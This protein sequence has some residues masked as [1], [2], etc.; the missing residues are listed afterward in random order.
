MAVRNHGDNDL[1]VL[2]DQWK[3]LTIAEGDC[4]A[5]EDWLRLDELQSQK[6]ASQQAIETAHASLLRNIS[7]NQRSAVEGRLKNIAKEVL[8]LESQN[9]ERLT[10]KL[11]QTSTELRQLDK[12]TRSMGRVHRAYGTADRS[13]WQ[14]YS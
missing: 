7:P 6:S 11:T 1:F 9:H 12:A 13:F 5:S 3:A 4:I 8:H 14:A 2:L 10:E